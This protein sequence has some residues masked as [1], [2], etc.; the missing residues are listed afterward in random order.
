M[1]LQDACD[2]VPSLTARFS[3]YLVQE[4]GDQFA[5]VAAPLY[6]WVTGCPADDGGDPLATYFTPMVT[7]ANHSY[8]NATREIAHLDLRRSCGIASRRLPPRRARSRR[9][10]RKCTR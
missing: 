2:H 9:A 5:G 6:G 1:M 7:A 4:Y 3:A 8:V 10:R